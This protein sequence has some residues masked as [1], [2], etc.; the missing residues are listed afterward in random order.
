MKLFSVTSILLPFRKYFAPTPT[1]K[2]EIMFSSISFTSMI[3]C[4]IKDNLGRVLYEQLSNEDKIQISS[5][6]E[7]SP[8]VCGDLR[9]ESAIN[10]GG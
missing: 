9:I 1:R 10:S 3:A 8:R 6:S 2:C 7:V 4:N 5:S